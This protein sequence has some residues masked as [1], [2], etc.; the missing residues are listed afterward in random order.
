MIYLNK[1]RRKERVLDL[2][3]EGKTYREIQQIVRVT[4]N[5]IS[6]VSKK[7]FGEENAITNSIK[8]LSKNTKA[9]QLFSQGKKPINIAMELDLDADLISK[10]YSDFIR[11]TNLTSFDYLL[12]NQHRDKLSLLVKLV[13]ILEKRGIKNIDS[14]KKTINEVRYHENLKK[15]INA[16]TQI[17]SNLKYEN[18]YLQHQIDEKTKILKRKNDWIRCLKFKNDELTTRIYKSKES[19][20]KLQRLSNNVCNSETFL[21]L[22]NILAYNIVDV[23]LSNDNK[24]ILIIMAIFECY[25]HDQ[26]M[27]NL[28]NEY[29]IEFERKKI[30]IDNVD[31]R[32]QYFKDSNIFAYISELITKLVDIYSKSILAFILEKYF[33]SK[34]MLSKTKVND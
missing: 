19:L 13:D 10:A 2:L 1:Q 12:N 15:E 34:M 8:N 11:L 3:N 17:S 14:I 33:A 32:I 21:D 4:P 7:E 6:T 24:I 25:R 23:I 26:K 18:Q 31:E 29:C 22:K 28:L 20:D 30:S 16:F 27:R 9:I 5:F